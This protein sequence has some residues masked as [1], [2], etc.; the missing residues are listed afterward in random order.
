MVVEV[1]RNLM[2]V[3][4]SLMDSL[5]QNSV[6]KAFGY[7]VIMFGTYLLMLAVMTYSTGLFLVAVSGH[8]IGFMISKIFENHL[9]TNK[10]E[11]TSLI[12]LKKN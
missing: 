4:R 11:S 3:R 10:D 2:A 12:I 9:Q 8:T 5:I 6:I 7:V 1:L